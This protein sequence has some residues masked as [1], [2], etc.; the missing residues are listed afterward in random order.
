MIYIIITTSINNKVGVQ[1]TIHRQNRY[2]ESIQQL[3]KLIDNDKTIKVIIVENNGFRKTFLDDLN[4]DICYTNNNNL[5][6]RH[7]GENE[8]LDIKH[9]I[10]QYKIQDDDVII[11]LTGRYKLLNLNFINLVK[12]NNN[13]D[14][15]VKFF[16]VCTKRYE[17]DD[18]V[19][20]LFAI[21]CKYL[22]DFKYNLLRSPECEFAD[23]IRKNINKE[24]LI[25]VEQ[26]YLEC[27]FADDLR[28]LIV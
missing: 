15:F 11:K 19:L 20:G 9:V 18:C 26:L 22:K 4:C 7:K 5:H 1:N 17:F 2:I 6:L 28:M 23:Y 24:K 21:K 27:C 13:L 8:L 3:L 10:N 14:A 25:E 16:N 12:A